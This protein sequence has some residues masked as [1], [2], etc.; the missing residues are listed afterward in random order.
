MQACRAP[1]GYWTLP[2]S[3]SALLLHEVE[4]KSYVR[5]VKADAEPKRK[6]SLCAGERVLELPLEMLKDIFQSLDIVERLR[7]RHTCQLWDAILTTAELCSD[8]RVSRQ[9][10]NAP[11]RQKWWKPISNSPAIIKSKTPP[12]PAPTTGAAAGDSNTPTKVL[13]DALWATGSRI[14]GGVEAQEESWPWIVALIQFRPEYMPPVYQFCAASLISDRWIVTAGHCVDNHPDDF[15]TTHIKAVVGITDI[16]Q[17]LT[18]PELL[19]PI[20]RVF[21]HPDYDNP[22]DNT[23]NDVALLELAEPVKFTSRIQPICLPTHPSTDLASAANIDKERDG[24]KVAFVAGWGHLVENQ[25]RSDNN[26]AVPILILGI[27][28]DKLQQVAIDLYDRTTCFKQLEEFT[29][30]D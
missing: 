28:S 18:Q 19:L 21:H 11:N 24:K 4:R 13:P 22:K 7:C 12:L 20:S 8:V 17:V 9:S 14:I 23:N 5:L 2:P 30:T 27:G 29:F 1:N 15:L 6:Q 10:S 3:E 25:G 26:F 16:K